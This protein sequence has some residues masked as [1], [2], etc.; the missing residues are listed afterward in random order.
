MHPFIYVFFPSIFVFFF[1]CQGIARRLVISALVKAARTRQIPF[2][3][4]KKLDQGVRRHVHDDI[5][6]VVIFIDHDV[7]DNESSA[8]ELSVRGFVDTIGPS[9]FSF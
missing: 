1:F 5:T 3:E 7:L 6:V 2:N 8:P 4:I 9:N